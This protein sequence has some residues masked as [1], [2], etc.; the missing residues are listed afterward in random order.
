MPTGFLTFIGHWTAAQGAELAKPHSKANRA[1]K[2]LAERSLTAS[3]WDS[4]SSMFSLAPEN[5]PW[6]PR[7]TKKCA[8]RQREVSKP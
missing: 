6:L 3:R 4:S 2:R 8:S 7:V 5:K 1:P